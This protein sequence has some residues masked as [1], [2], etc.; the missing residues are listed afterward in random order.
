MRIKGPCPISSKLSPWFLFG[1]SGQE[2]HD[3]D[4]QHYWLFVLHIGVHTCQFQSPIHPPPP[5]HG[6]I[7]FSLCLHRSVLWIICTIS[8]FHIYMLIH[9]T[10]FSLFDLLCMIDSKA[11]IPQFKKLELHNLPVPSH[12][13]TALPLTM[14]SDFLNFF[15][16]LF[17]SQNN[18]GI[19]LFL[20]IKKCIWQQNMLKYWDPS[21]VR[22]L[23]ISSSFGWR[24]VLGILSNKG[25]ILW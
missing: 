5:V 3:F 11:S 13:H 14:F 9:D 8:R 25:P 4:Q 21:I 19:K 6:Y 1:F 18:H 24:S 16:N 17:F 20:L 15:A 22:I 7:F 23:L 2:S 10:C 12:F